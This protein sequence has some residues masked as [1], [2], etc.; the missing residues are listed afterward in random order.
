MHA[1]LLALLLTLGVAGL[2]PSAGPPP[3]LVPDP[4]VQAAIGGAVDA[5][6]AGPGE[7]ERREAV[8]RAGD[9]AGSSPGGRVA[10]LEQLQIFLSTAR[11]TEE[12]MGS[13][14]LLHRLEFGRDEILAATLPHLVAAGPE[15]NK[16]LREVASTVVDPDREDDPVALVLEAERLRRGERKPEPGGEESHELEVLLR[17]LAQDDSP[18]VRRYAAAAAA[19][20]ME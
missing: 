8:E 5:L 15:L 18:W 16:V 10:L 20:P 13:A 9:L 14:L 4:A 12:A 1:A 6:N 2:A 7:V 3:G 11:G 17:R 19:N